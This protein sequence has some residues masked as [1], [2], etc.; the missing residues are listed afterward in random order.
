MTERPI[1]KALLE[2]LRLS[3][4]RRLFGRIAG[5]LGVVVTFHRVR[6][7]V[8]PDEFAPNAHLEVTPEFLG[9]LIDWA[10]K[11]GIDLVT[12]DEAK[13]RLGMASPRRFLVI[14]MDDGYRDN[15]EFALPILKDRNCP[16]T[17][18][19]AT[20]FVDRTANPWWMTLE[21]AILRRQSVDHP[22]GSGRVFETATEA[23]K[24]SAYAQ[25]AQWL[26]AVSEP[27]QRE[28]IDEL[29]KQCRVDVTALNKDA[30]MSWDEVREIASEPLVTIGAH[31]DAHYALA[32]L[33]REEAKRDILKGVS[34]LETHLGR[35]PR[36]FAYPYGFRTAVGPRDHRL[37]A[38]LGFS[39]AVLTSPG[40]LR[41]ENLAAP[42]AWPRISMNG[43]F[44]A[45]RYADVLISGVPFWPG[46]VADRLFGRN[47]ASTSRAPVSASSG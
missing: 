15:L 30:F 33:S 4:L 44:Q 45:I 8:E 37:V 13:R 43:H 12:L 1:E 39:T 21:E 46:H 2:A 24:A 19:V 27:R 20:G 9:D 42:T 35:R 28:A 16:F 36:H 29:A 41:T 34:I 10:Q 17:I 6:P 40:V 32:K 47:F 26:Q 38:E 5:G 14:T 18:Y 23:E 11:S 3:G 31:T 25:L 7:A 22:D